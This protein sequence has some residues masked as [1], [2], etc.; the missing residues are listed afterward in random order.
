M[1]QQERSSPREQIH[2]VPQ[3]FCSSCN[4]VQP[5]PRLAQS[6][7][8]PVTYFSLFNLAQRF[9][10]NLKELE[11]TY[12]SYQMKLHPDKFFTRSPQEREFSERYAS[13]VNRAYNTLKRPNLRAQYILQLEGN[14]IEEGDSM[15]SIDKEF[16]LDVMEVMEEVHD[17]TSSQERLQEVNQLLGGWFANA[18]RQAT[19]IFADTQ[20]QLSNRKEWV[21]NAR[22]IAAVLNYL[23]R[24]C[25]AII[26]R[27]EVSTQHRH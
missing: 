21:T 13:E 16:L 8:D 14:A 25:D 22:R 19:N 2:L 5:P 20:Q 1:K 7:N 6:K 4:T 9:D 10:I 11:Q 23:Q 12:K 15:E 18:E 24:I 27:L 3:F 26:P 17:P